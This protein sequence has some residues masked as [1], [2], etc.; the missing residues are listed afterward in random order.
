MINKNILKNFRLIVKKALQQYFDKFDE[1]LSDM[2]IVTLS[3][4]KSHKDVLKEYDL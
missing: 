4:E 1:Y 2:R 3:K